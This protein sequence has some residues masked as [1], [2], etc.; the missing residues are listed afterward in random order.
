MS[1]AVSD[2]GVGLLVQPIYTASLVEH[3]LQS[4]ASFGSTCEAYGLWF[5]GLFYHRSF[6]WQPLV[7]TDF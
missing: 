6:V 7:Q 2:L 4:K 5:I 1:L 3:L